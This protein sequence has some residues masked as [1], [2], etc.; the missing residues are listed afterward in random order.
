MAMSVELGKSLEDFVETLVKSGRYGSRSE[1]LREGIRLVQEREA[2]ARALD[3]LLAEA[4]ADVE[5]G[6]TR[7][8][9]EVFDELLSELSALK[10]AK[11]AS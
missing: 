2:K 11:D 10:D 5:A 1:V 8:M 7:P 9:D 4:H 6:R 3:L